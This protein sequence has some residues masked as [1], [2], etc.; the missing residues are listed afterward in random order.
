MVSVALQLKLRTATSALVDRIESTVLVV[1]Q[2]NLLFELASRHRVEQVSSDAG[3]GITRPL[4]R[5][6]CANEV[7]PACLTVV[8]ELDEDILGPEPVDDRKAAGARLLHPSP[9]SP[10][11][12]L[13]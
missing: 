6:G 5:R 10:R 13:S 3:G 7:C 2:L 4:G 11:T 9:E 8:V 12:V 1:E